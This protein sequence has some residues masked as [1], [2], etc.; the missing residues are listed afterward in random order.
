MTEKTE[1]R[2]SVDNVLRPEAFQ[3]KASSW[4]LDGSDAVLLFNLQKSDFDEKYY[5]NIGI[6]LKALGCEKFP[7]ENRCHIQARLTSLFPDQVVLIE[8]GCRLDATPADL[9]D[10]LRLVKE[11]FV[12]L[13]KQCVSLTE[14]RKK[15]AAGLF[16][17]ALVM[18]VARQAME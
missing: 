13:A 1:L 9:E 14:L 8:R 17:N 15:L 5:V 18:Q 11:E 2:K 3:R 4:Y 6:W 10:F 12:P 7:T 16:D